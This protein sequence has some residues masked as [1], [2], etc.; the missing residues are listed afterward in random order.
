[1]AAE[2]AEAARQ[3]LEAEGERVVAIGR[4]EPGTGEAS[5]A[6]APPPGWFG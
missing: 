3:R 5:V 4:I 2:K 1:V 6:I